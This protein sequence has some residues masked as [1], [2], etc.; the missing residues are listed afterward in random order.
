[1]LQTAHGQLEQLGA[2]PQNAVY[3]FDRLA[4]E[5]PPPGPLPPVIKTQ[6]RRVVSLR[7]GSMRCREVLRQTPGAGVSASGL[8][9]LAPA[10]QRYAYDLIAHVGLSYYLRGQRLLTIQQDL[11][12]RH[13]AVKIPSSSLSDLCG[14]FLYLLGHLHRRAA[15]RL[16]ESW[17]GGGQSVWLAD[18]TQERDSPAF[19]GVLETHH[20]VLLGCWKVPSENEPDLTPCLREVVEQFGKPGRFLHDLSS[21]MAA[22]REAVLPDVPDG[23]CHFHFARDVGMDLY[24]RPHQQ[25]ANRLKELRLQVRLREQR[26][27][28]V[29][30][31]RRQ[32]A[33][34]EAPLL[35]RRL[36]LGES[37]AVAWTAALGREVLLAV[38]FWILDHEHEGRR[39]GYPFDPHLLYLHRRLIRAGEALARLVSPG[40]LPAGM[41]LCLANL[42]ERLRE[43]RDDKVIADAAACYE[44][45]CAV[46]GELRQTLRL[47]GTGG[48]P[49]SESYELSAAEQ[50]TVKEEL[51]GLCGRWEQARQSSGRA[52]EQEIYGIVLAHVRRYEGKLAYEGDRPLNKEGDRTTNALEA[53]WRQTKRRCRQRHGRAELV[54]DMRVL[55]ATA[56]LV[57]DLAIKEYVEVV[58]GT[59]EQLPERLAE[60]GTSVPPFRGGKSEK[61]VEKAGQLPRRWLRQGNFLEELL[62]VCPPPDHS[63]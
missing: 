52:D 2:L 9:R 31:L 19:F 49:L 62:A 32:V 5:T 54:R 42:A 36:L 60:I 14:E 16:R 20:G 12:Q 30:Y 47:H 46:F 33:G 24:R 35:L 57:G 50:R 28:Q 17:Q 7:Y 15:S 61:T 58:C 59:L 39:H 1:L 40:P 38:H 53:W 56:L 4:Q 22:L 21:T 6:T 55:P 51:L 48:T 26:K 27:D 41:P 45:A 3:T 18:C 8:E 11:Q 25:M 34:G 37:P 23:V 63:L 44:K 29:D 43:Y 10:G 13:A